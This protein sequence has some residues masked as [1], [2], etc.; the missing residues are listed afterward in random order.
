[1]KKNA[2]GRMNG[3]KAQASKLVLTLSAIVLVSKTYKPAPIKPAPPV[4]LPHAA[5]EK[6]P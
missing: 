1:M 6:C 3:R 4:P 5:S 2:I